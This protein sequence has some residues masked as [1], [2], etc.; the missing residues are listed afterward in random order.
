MGGATRPL[1]GAQGRKSI[2]AGAE[3]PA[4]ALSRSQGNHYERAIGQLSA[5]LERLELRGSGANGAAAEAPTL[6][7]AAAVV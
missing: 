6:P 5:L 4:S 2:P 1:E 7:A 3:L